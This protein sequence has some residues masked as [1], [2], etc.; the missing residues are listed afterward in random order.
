MKTDDRWCGRRIR[1]TTRQ[2]GSPDPADVCPIHSD[3]VLREVA[4]LSYQLRKRRLPGNVRHVAVQVRNSLRLLV[5]RVAPRIVKPAS[6]PETFEQKVRPSTY[7]R[8][9]LGVGHPLRKVDFVKAKE[10]TLVPSIVPP[11]NNVFK[12]RGLKHVADDPR[13][14]GTFLEG[15]ASREDRI[16]QFNLIAP[17]H[18]VVYAQGLAR[19]KVTH[20]S[21]ISEAALIEAGNSMVDDDMV[22]LVKLNAAAKLLEATPAS[23]E[24]S[25][26]LALA[27]LLSGESWGVLKF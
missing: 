3:G 20:K 22:N 7:S 18:A 26:A 8:A 13:V 21:L 25:D 23:K 5:G 12:I 11:K 17:E 14:V 27:K 19:P 1:K 6:R 4:R 15:P 10:D 24:A 16:K 9:R 2:A